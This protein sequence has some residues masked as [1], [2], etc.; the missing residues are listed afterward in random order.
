MSKDNLSS[1][2]T[3]NRLQKRS[4]PW[5]EPVRLV[6]A[7]Q[8][9]RRAIETILVKKSS[10]WDYYTKIYSLKLGENDPVVVAER[11]GGPSFDLVSVHRCPDLSHDQL[12]M[13][14]SIQHPNFVTVHE[15]Y[16]EQYG[17]HIVTEHM[18][19]SLQEAVGNPLLDG[20]KLAAITGQVRPAKPP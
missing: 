15:V 13:L 18:P 12:E 3:P 10:P 2:Q 14:Q 11:K 16:Q 20:P 9:G 17:W 6:K 19:R 7:N 4:A 8:D 1:A 5:V